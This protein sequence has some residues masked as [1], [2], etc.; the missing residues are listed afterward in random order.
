MDVAEPLSFEQALGQLENIVEQME[1]GDLSLEQLMN[2]V[3]NG[4]KLVKLCQS[5]LNRA[6]TRINEL[7]KQM[8]GSWKEKPSSLSALD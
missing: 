1:S 5:H 8:D 2:S 7:E 3:E 6:E 4:S